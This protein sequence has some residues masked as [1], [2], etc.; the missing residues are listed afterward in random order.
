MIC[1]RYETSSRVL[2]ESMSMGCPLVVARVGGMTEA[3]E[4]GVDALSHRTEDP[5]DLSDKIVALLNDP[6]R[7]AELGGKAA[8]SSHAEIS[9]GCDNT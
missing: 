9:P 8:A 1:S 4:D 6:G 5:A 7:A 3:F 2:I